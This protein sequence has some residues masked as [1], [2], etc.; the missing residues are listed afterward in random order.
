MKLQEEIEVLTYCKNKGREMNSKTFYR[1]G[2]RYGFVK[3]DEF[4]KD[5]FDKW[6]DDTTPD[7]YVSFQTIAKEN[8][9][10][11]SSVKNQVIRQGIEVKRITSFYNRG[12]YVKQSDVEKIVGRCHKRSQAKNKE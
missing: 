11:Y 6:V 4:N 5:V 12:M 10:N 7:G 1:Q 3:N 9:L 2:E 8:N